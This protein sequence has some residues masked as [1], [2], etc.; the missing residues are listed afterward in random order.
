MDALLVLV[1]MRWVCVAEG[2]RKVRE[3]RLLDDADNKPRYAWPR[4]L[5]Q[6]V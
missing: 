5:S 2:M 6:W 3:D 4:P 1:L